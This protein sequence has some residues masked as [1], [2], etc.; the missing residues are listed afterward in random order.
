MGADEEES[1]RGEVKEKPTDLAVRETLPIN[2]VMRRA[3]NVS[4]V[5][6]QE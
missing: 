4:L 3:L 5:V 2:R 1:G 6:N